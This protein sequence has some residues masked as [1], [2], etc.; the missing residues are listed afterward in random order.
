TDPQGKLTLRLY[1]VLEGKDLWKKNFG[2][3][4]VVLHTEDP[5]LAGVVEADGKVTVIDL[6]ARKEAALG[7]DRNGKPIVA[8]VDPKHL[9]KAQAV[10]LLRDSMNSYVLVNGP[11][12]PNQNPFG[13]PMTNLIPGS[14]IRALPVNGY[15]Y[16]FPRGV[17]EMWHSIDKVEHQ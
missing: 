3:N 16:G 7:Q 1:D 6:V 5:D 9:E 10:Y 4:T 13:G 14:G 17:G 8:R 12:D 2:P 11:L 15:V